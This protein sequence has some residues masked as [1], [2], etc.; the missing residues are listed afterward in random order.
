MCMAGQN[1]V[2]SCL[3]LLALVSPCCSNI[4]RQGN[5]G[6]A[7]KIETD[8]R[9][10]RDGF[11]KINGTPSFII[12]LYELP[13]DNE[14]L[15]GIAQ[16]GFN[17]VRVPGD[18]NELNRVHKHNLYAWICLNSA[19]KLSENDQPGK[20]ILTR[21]VN[22]FKDHPAL[23]VWELPDETVWN[24]WWSRSGWISG[25]QQSE[26]RKNIEKARAGA[27]KSTIAKWLSLLQ[28]AEDYDARG[29]WQQAEQIYDTLWNELA[30]NNPH[31]DWKMSQC[32]AQAD[33][34]TDAIARGCQV[35]RQLDSKHIIWQN[36]APRNS[37]QRLQKYNKV[38]DAAGCD[39]YPVPA[40]PAVGHSDL[41]D[42]DLSAVGAY[43]DRMRQTAPGKSI[44]LVLQGFGWRDLS[45]EGKNDPDLNKGRRPNFH[46]TR[47]M[48]F[49][50]VVH[51]ANA[52]LYW[53]TDYIEKDSPLWA[54]L[55][56][57]CRQLRALEPAIVGER[58]KVL[59][60]AVA[61]E[62]FGS[63]DKQG[64]QLMLTKTDGDW[65]LIAVNEHAQGVSFRINN[66][67]KEIEGGTL[68][69]LYS[70]EEHIVQSVSFRDGIR[71][72]GVHIYATT[73]RFEAK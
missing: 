28:T 2:L 43:T 58:P 40:S 48:A 4:H 20:Q 12:G 45:A 63:I 34:L 7:R 3:A 37:V 69:R 47:F 8:N 55:M 46:E 30:V 6:Y 33:E 67:P 39:I 56:K 66:L 14:R 18:V 27:S 42:R 1:K 68:Y 53:G 57:V 36:H 16:S 29:L 13:K 10:T 51:G 62:T 38:V 22:S 24:V 52:I 54:D 71:G 21:I 41:K 9:F 25:G 59:P 17:L 73:R 72:F 60:T 70:E 32:P 23:L 15:R 61:D 50:A 35:V 5:T 19:V 26:L 44:W 65:V 31:P 64:P 11:L 49:D